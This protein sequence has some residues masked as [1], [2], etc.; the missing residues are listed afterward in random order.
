MN[1][2]QELAQIKARVDLALYAQA[3]HRIELN[4]KGWGRCP[5][6]ENHNHGDA[7]PSL[8]LY[9]ERLTC[10]SQRCFD[11]DD[12]FGLEMKMSRVG[13]AEAKRIVLGRNGKASLTES[14][15]ENGDAIGPNV[16]T[17]S[18][19]RIVGSYEYQ[20][21]VG[22]VVYRIDRWEGG[23]MGKDF[24]ARPAGV[25]KKD[26]ILY[27]LPELDAADG[28]LVIVEG[29]KKVDRLRDLG[30][31]ATTCAYGSGAWLPQYAE[32]L[33]D[34]DVIMWPDK[35][36]PG[37][38]HGE[39]VLRSLVGVA[40]LRR[41]QPPDD[42]PAGGD[43]MDVSEAEVRRL[44]DEAQPWVPLKTASPDEATTDDG[45]A[46]DE[47][48]IDDDRAEGSKAELLVKLVLREGELFHDQHQT[49]HAYVM[50]KEYSE[51]LRCRGRRFR[52]W[53]S[54]LFYE[55]EGK[56]MASDQFSSALNVLEGTPFTTA[57]ST[58]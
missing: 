8:Q 55:Q 51:V 34:R 50:V 53:A 42:L 7:D 39:I 29:E 12:V 15:S 31:T 38:E 32:A 6:P 23:G 25:P 17:D 19:R 28:V 3:Y 13:L 45:Q 48:D 5:F 20:N 40:S 30:Y 36:V 46:D 52:Q 44:I 14:P 26:R 9:K 57:A 33:R 58:S 2:R 37:E 11:G 18:T 27:R 56:A 47:A 1:G 16:P 21:R 4:E 54:R 35:D 41:V 43:V 24:R 10:H 49:P 22:D